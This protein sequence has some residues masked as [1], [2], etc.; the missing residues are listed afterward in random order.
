MNFF[1]LKSQIGL[2]YK[3]ITQQ[4]NFLKQEDLLR[5]QKNKKTPSDLLGVFL[6]FTLRQHLL[7]EDHDRL[8]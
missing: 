4:V 7:L 6:F 1:F 8:Q 2:A 5:T 3:T